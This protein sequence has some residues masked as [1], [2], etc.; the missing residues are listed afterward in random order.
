MIHILY[1]AAGQSRRYGSNKLL[2]NRNGKPLYRYGLDTIRKAISNRSNCT[3]TVITCWPAIEKAMHAEGIQ[4]VQCPESHLGISYT[5][6]T[7]IHS[8][9]TL[10]ETDYLCF[11]VADQP[12]L[13]LESITR[14]LDA[15]EHHPITACLSSDG[16]YGNPV[17]FSAKLAPELLALE[18]DKGGK[19]VMKKH[20]ENHIDIPCNF[21]EL[22]DIDIRTD[23]VSCP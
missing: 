17:L 20:P 15:V 14:L 4:T 7:G 6:K 2:E 9:G 8:C 18:G 16:I 13:T 10:S 22:E 11:S 5:I 19:S 3:L 1:L 12:N 23:M 21:G